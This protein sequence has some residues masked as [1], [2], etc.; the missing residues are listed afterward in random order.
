MEQ[1]SLSDQSIERLDAAQQNIYSSP[2]EQNFMTREDDGAS[3]RYRKLIDIYNSCSFALTAGDLV[4]Y[5]GAAKSEHWI[6]AM[7]EEM[8]TINKNQT[9]ELTTLP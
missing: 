6:M 4:S 5:E 3:T 1:C 2:N 7:K 9:W 8:N